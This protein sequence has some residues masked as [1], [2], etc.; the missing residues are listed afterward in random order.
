MVYTIVLIVCLVGGP[1]SC[2]E[3][4][5]IAHGLAAHPSMA[6]IQAQTLVA[7]WLDEHP[8]LVVRRRSLKPGR[9]A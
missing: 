7:Q 8:G 3:R 4:E 6:F 1:Q 2:E 5:Q 9:G